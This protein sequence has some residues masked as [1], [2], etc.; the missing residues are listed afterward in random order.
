MRVT[1]MGT[2]TG[3]ITEGMT[4]GRSVPGVAFS[5]IPSLNS[6]GHSD[7]DRSARMTVCFSSSRRPF[8]GTGGGPAGHT[9]CPRGSHRSDM[10]PSEAEAARRVVQAC[11]SSHSQSSRSRSA[12]Y[13]SR[14]E[15]MV[16][17]RWM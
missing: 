12:S 6:L 5:P 13:D 7:C 11:R 3:T 4:G 9:A 16:R 1:G 10:T 17:V 14:D 2:G 8:L 15:L